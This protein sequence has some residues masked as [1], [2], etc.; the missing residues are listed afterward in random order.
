MDTAEIL[1]IIA[2]CKRE[3]SGRV[4]FDSLAVSIISHELEPIKM[5]HNLDVWIGRDWLGKTPPEV[6]ANLNAI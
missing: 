6:M 3:L 5:A 1:A 4:D 2:E